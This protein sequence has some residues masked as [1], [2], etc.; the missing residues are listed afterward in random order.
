MLKR[1]MPVLVHSIEVSEFGL[2]YYGF[3]CLFQMSIGYVMFLCWNRILPWHS[4]DC[5]ALK[6]FFFF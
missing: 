1:V 4:K 3:T 2:L 6:F 5:S